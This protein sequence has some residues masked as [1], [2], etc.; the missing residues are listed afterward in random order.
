M[1]SR[2]MLALP[3]LIHGGGRWTLPLCDATALAVAGALV[4]DSDSSRAAKLSAAL[5]VDPAFAVW[6]VFHER[7]ATL[8]ID[9]LAVSLAGR[10]IDLL[11]QPDAGPITFSADH[12]G[13]F[14][15]LVAES[16]ATASETT[17]AAG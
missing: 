2:M 7:R 4:D 10:L 15:A 12:H 5:I 17:R 11:D 16:V 8:S 1:K 3:A 6:V 9:S 14:A 13:R